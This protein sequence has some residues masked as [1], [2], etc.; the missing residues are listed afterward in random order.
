MP[1]V[2]P[3]NVIHDVKTSNAVCEI[4]ETLVEVLKQSR[5][6]TEDSKASTGQPGDIK[7]K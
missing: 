2:E 5:K 1:N 4:G 3:E 7:R 6:F